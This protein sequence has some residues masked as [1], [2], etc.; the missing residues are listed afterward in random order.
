M[1]RVGEARLQAVEEAGD[2]D[3]VAGLGVVVG[4]RAQVRG[5]APDGVQDDQAAAPRVAAPAR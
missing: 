5:D 2:Q 4:E 3:L 1:S